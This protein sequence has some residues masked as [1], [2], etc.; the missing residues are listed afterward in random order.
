MFYVALICLTQATSPEGYWLVRMLRNYLQL[1]SL[2]GL[3]IHTESTLIMIEE[4]LL[5][6]DKE[7]K[8]LFLHRIYYL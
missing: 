5:V 7:L 1:D 8:V 3:N 2:I 6:F 4:E